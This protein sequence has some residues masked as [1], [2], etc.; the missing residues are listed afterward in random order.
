MPAQIVPRDTQNWC[1][2]DFLREAHLMPTTNTTRPQKRSYEVKDV[3]YMAH[4]LREALPDAFTK[5]VLSGSFSGGA[6]V[7]LGAKDHD[8][9]TPEAITASRTLLIPIVTSCPSRVPNQFQVA[10]ALLLLHSSLSDKLLKIPAGNMHATPQPHRL[11]Q[12]RSTQIETK[13]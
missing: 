1:L 7:L 5:L 3:A 13:N 6:L 10:D 8:E 12:S 2:D 4:S 9:A 11:I